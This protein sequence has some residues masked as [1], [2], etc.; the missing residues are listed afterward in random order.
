[1]GLFDFFSS[2]PKPKA[3]NLPESIYEFKLKSLTGKEVAM[4]EFK[5]KQL[6]IVNTASKCGKT[7]QYEDLQKLHEQ[8]GKQVAVL[9]FPAN[10]FLRQEPGTNEDIAAFCEMNYGVTFPMFQKISVKGN[11]QHPLY[12]WLEEKT[13]KHP[14]WNF[15]KYL[16]SDDGKTAEFFKSGVKVSDPEVTE[17]LKA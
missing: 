3:Q 9:G 6:L 1:M 11:D 2:K 7:P 17:K 16:I 15:S 10:N 4:A 5:G 8:H 14:D 12:Q 13:G